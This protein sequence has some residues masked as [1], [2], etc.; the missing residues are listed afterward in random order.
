MKMTTEQIIREQ[1][2]LVEACHSLDNDGS[3]MRAFRNKVWYDID[4]EEEN[5]I[6]NMKKL[7]K[8]ID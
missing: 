5:E 8:P 7:C 1:Y 2:R 6:E 3:E 4:Y